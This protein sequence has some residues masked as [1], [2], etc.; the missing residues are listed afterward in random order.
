[1]TQIRIMRNAPDWAMAHL[2]GFFTRQARF[3]ETY[4]HAP[5]FEV[6]RKGFVVVAI[7]RCAKGYPLLPRG[8][9]E[10]TIDDR[11][12]WELPSEDEGKSLATWL[13]SFSRCMSYT[14]RVY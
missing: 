6:H 1:M 4:V 11:A 3:L 8:V 5:V 14:L 12:C 2:A 7:R 10:G 9:I 13:Q